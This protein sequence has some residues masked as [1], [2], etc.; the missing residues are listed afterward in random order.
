MDVEVVSEL[1]VV[2]VEMWRRR[3]GQ[4]EESGGGDEVDLGSEADGMRDTATLGACVRSQQNFLQ[5]VTTT[6]IVQTLLSGNRIHAVSCYRAT[7]VASASLYTLC[8]M[9]QKTVPVYVVAKFRSFWRGKEIN[10]MHY[11]LTPHVLKI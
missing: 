5:L 9:I 1:I 10:A 7:R 6:S 8:A 3:G 2:V 11:P 4:E